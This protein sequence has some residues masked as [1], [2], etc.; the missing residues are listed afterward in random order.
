MR[1]MPA[2]PQP[3][4]DLSTFRG[5]LI[6][7]ETLLA[8][9]DKERF[10]HDLFPHLLSLNET[11]DSWHHRA[12]ALNSEGIYTYFGK[13]WTRGNLEL[14]F[15]SFWANGSEYSWHQHNDQINKL[16]ALLME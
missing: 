2:T 12:V 11:L 7:N 9:L 5:L 3:L 15:K 10:R 1:P 6:M 14:F 16:E 4:S 8:V 13:K